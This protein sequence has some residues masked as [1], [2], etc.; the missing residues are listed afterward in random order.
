MTGPI[1]LSLLGLEGTKRTKDGLKHMA[2][3]DRDGPLNRGPRSQPS[4]HLGPRMDGPENS[5][6]PF[7]IHFLG[8]KS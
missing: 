3:K 1:N 6:R 8:Q 4:N 7:V 5:I 2:H